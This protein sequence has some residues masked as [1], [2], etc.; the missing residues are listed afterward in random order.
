MV[1]THEMGGYRGCHGSD[2]FVLPD[3]LSPDDGFNLLGALVRDIHYFLHGSVLLSLWMVGR[4]F[5]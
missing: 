5:S 3:D 2:A 4:W 1:Y